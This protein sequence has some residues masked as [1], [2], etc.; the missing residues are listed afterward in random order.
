MINITDEERERR[1]QNMLKLHDE[2]RAGAE[3]GKMGGRPRKPR[4]S[5]Q[6]AERVINDADTFYERLRDIAIDGTEKNAISAIIALLKTEEQE[7]KIQVEEEDKVDQL[8]RDELISLVA[9][10][11]GELRSAGILEER[12]IGVGVAEV[13]RDEGTEELSEAPN[14]T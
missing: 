4:A 12:T 14:G 3:F 11:L 2:G 5:E 6:I 9:R 10:Q 7:R 1:R 8:R 13:V